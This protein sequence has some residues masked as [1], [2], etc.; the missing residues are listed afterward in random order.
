MILSNSL[1]AFFV[2]MVSLLN[3]PSLAEE[4]EV[5]GDS[6]SL[7]PDFFVLSI[8]PPGGSVILQGG[9]RVT[10]RAPFKVSDLIRDAAKITRPPEALLSVALLCS[11]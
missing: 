9:H 5:P 1:G 2:L 10:G 4:V 8:S 6:L 3:S 7:M 11:P